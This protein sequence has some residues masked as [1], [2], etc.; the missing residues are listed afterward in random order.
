MSLRHKDALTLLFP[1]ELGGVFHGDTAVEGASLDATADSAERLLSE[2]FPD[3]AVELLPDWERVCG[4]YPQEGDPLQF[5]R[6]RVVRKLRELGDIKKPYFEMLAATLGYQIH[7]EEYIPTMAEWAGAGDELIVP[8]DPAVLFVWNFHILNQEI[9][10]FRAGQSLAGDH[11]SW[12]NPA[13]ELEGILQD[14]RPAHV[15]F[16]FTYE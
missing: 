9:H 8:D 3:T 6:D 7:I 16:D 14:L 11:L 13:D 4:V 12:W 15:R 5:R 1:L 2:M 10:Y